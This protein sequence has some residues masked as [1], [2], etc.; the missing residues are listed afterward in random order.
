M[1]TIIYLI[2]QTVTFFAGAHSIFYE[3]ICVGQETLPHIVF[4][5]IENTNGKFV[6][7]EYSFEHARYTIK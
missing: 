4:R 5:N 3:G 1:I 6:C 2:V 7:D